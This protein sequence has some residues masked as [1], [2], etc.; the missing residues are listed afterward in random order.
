MC[1]RESYFLFF[2]NVLS[3][4]YFF[5]FL[6]CF[7]FFLPYQKLNFESLI[8]FKNNLQQNMVIQL[9]MSK[10]KSPYGSLDLGHE[11]NQDTHSKPNWGEMIYAENILQCLFQIVLKD[12]QKQ[13]EALF[14][15]SDLS[16]N[17]FGHCMELSLIR[18][19]IKCMHTLGWMCGD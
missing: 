17:K 9:K 3:K 1:L 4:F 2:W 13:W 12:S 18:T 16:S 10:S 15:V 14:F 7:F 6:A 11:H 5:T 8:H 19:S